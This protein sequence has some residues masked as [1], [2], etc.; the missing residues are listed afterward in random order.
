MYRQHYG[1]R[2]GISIHRL[3]VRAL[4][5]IR[6]RRIILLGSVNPAIRRRFVHAGDTTRLS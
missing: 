2:L 6:A 3:D 1:C 5:S 4:F